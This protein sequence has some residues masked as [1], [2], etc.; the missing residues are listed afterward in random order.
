MLKFE[1]EVCCGPDE[2]KI[3]SSPAKGTSVESSLSSQA[4]VDL[5]EGVE[6]KTCEHDLNGDVARLYSNSSMWIAYLVLDSTRQ[7]SWQCDMSWDRK[8]DSL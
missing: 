2:S 7:R 1:E 6:V 8:S 3:W 5:P 4:G